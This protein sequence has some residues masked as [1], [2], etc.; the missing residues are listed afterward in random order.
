MRIT[1][2]RINGKVPGP[3]MTAI[4]FELQ[5]RLDRAGFITEVETKTTSCL[6]IGLWMKTFTLNP[7]MHERNYQNN[8]FGGRLT[9]LP[10]W[11]Q[12]VEFNDIVSST[13]NKFKVSAKVVSGPYTIRDG[14]KVF[15]EDDWHEQKPD[16]VRQ[17]ESRGYY[18]D[19]IDEKSF[20]E[21]R[22][23]KRLAVAREKRRQAKQC[24]EQRPHL[25]LGGS[26]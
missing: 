23:L 13:L 3:A 26:K 12:R 6:K 2:M 18:I 17:N 19:S 20:L 8:P 25:V 4:V 9:Y 22:R 16:W 14:M 7:D 15:T 11:D 10:N 24:V 1:K 21:E 5:R